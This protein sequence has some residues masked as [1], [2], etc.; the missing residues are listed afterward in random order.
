MIRYIME[1]VKME[2][3][4]WNGDDSGGVTDFPDDSAVIAAVSRGD[5]LFIGDGKPWLLVY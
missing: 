2:V 4:M 5:L 3:L 1:M